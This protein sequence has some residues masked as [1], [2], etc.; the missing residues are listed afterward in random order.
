M[1]G[2]GT[3]TLTS[4]CAWFRDRP[5]CTR[6][7]CPAPTTVASTM[8]RFFLLFFFQAGVFALCSCR[9]DATYVAAFGRVSFDGARMTSYLL[10]GIASC[11]TFRAVDSNRCGHQCSLFRPPVLDLCLPF[12]PPFL[13]DLGRYIFG[14]RM[15]F[16]YAYRDG[17]PGYMSTR[18]R[19][20]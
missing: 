15:C 20:G 7:A 14:V 2:E 8:L 10:A 4:A 16:R 3:F 12:P 6:R 1:P 18:S 5:S 19:H 11:P 9:E 17:N 13:F